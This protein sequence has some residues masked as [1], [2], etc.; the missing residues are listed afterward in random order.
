MAYYKNL[1][2]HI[3]ALEAAGKLVRVKREI[4]K[5]TELMP[6]VRW[7]FRGLGESQRGAFLFEKVVDVKGIK[8]DIPV[9]VASY[10]AS[11]EVYALGMMCRPEEISEKSAPA[12]PGW[13]RTGS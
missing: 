13:V 9:L 11:R 12:N 2:E 8:Y 6:L 3:S 5:D 10:A 1:R 4:N 7:Q